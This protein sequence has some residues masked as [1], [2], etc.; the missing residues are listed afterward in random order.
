MFGRFCLHIFLCMFG[1][2]LTILLSSTPARAEI[3]IRESSL[4]AC[5]FTYS[6]SPP[7]SQ[8]ADSVNPNGVRLNWTDATV[9][10]CEDVL[11]PVRVFYIALPPGATARLTVGSVNTEPLEKGLA[12]RPPG[13]TPERKLPRSAWA[14]LTGIESWRGFRLARIEV[15]LQV[16]DRNHS[17]V[18]RRIELTV[19]FTGG[20][21]TAVH[22]RD[23]RILSRMAVNG[24]AAA[25]WWEAPQRRSTLDEEGSWPAY[26]LVRLGVTEAG[27]YEISGSSVAASALVGQPSAKIK[28]FGNG[29]RLLPKDPTA[30][31]DSALIEN[32]IWVLDGGDGRFDHQDTILFYGRGLKGADYCDGTYLQG[33][34]HYSPFSTEN[35]YFLGIDPAG[36]DG[37]RMAP[38]A[39]TG[40]AT[41]ISTSV[42]RTYLEQDVYVYGGPSQPE[43]G[44]MWYMSTLN[45]GQE[46]TFVMNLEGA[47]GRRVRLTFHGLYEGS[48]SNRFTIYLNGVR[49]PVMSEERPI[50]FSVPG[51]TVAIPG[52]NAIRLV[53][54]SSAA[55]HVNY[56]EL[57]Y[58]RTIS[59][60]LGSVEFFAP[61]SVDG[62]FRYSIPEL[63]TSAYVLNITN[64][65]APRLAASSSIV[66]STRASRRSR[67]F[68]TRASSMRT[69]AYRGSTARHNLDYVR[70]R[71]PSNSADMVILTFDE[72][73][74]LLDSLRAFH[75]TYR[76]QPLRTMRVRLTDV[77]DEFGWGV[78]DVVAIRNFLKYAFENWQPTASGEPLRYVLLVGDGDYDY[79]NIISNADANWMPPWEF[80]EDCCDDFF[81]VFRNNNDLPQCMTGRWPVQG[82]AELQAVMSKTIAYA[83]HPLYG[84]WKNTATFAADDEWKGPS[85]GET[86]HTTQ[87]ESLINTILPDYFTFKKIY[88]ILY[89]FRSTATGAT[90]PDATRDLIEAINRG[91][92][93]VNYTGHG[94]ERVWT[95]EQLF[96]M[97]RDRN[98]LDNPRTWPLFLA[99]TCTWGGFD[100]P[101]GRCFP[102][103]L[104]ADRSDGAIAC[105]AATRFTYVGPN[106]AFTNAYYSEL[107]RPG[108]AE[109]SSFGEALMVAKTAFN[110]NAAQYLTF[111]DPVLRLAT[112]EYFARVTQ[113]GD[114]LRAL[115][116]FHLSGEVS[117]TDT[118]ALW[119]DFQ[120]VVEA[121]VYDTEDSA[122]YYWCN[123]TSS[124]PFYY[125]LPGNAIFRGRA[126]VRN[127]R[128]DIAFLVPR[129]V[130]FG[131]TNAKISLYFFGRSD[132]DADSADGIGIQE[133]LAIASVASSEQDT[134]PPT[135][136]LWL[137]TASFRSGDVVSP[138]PRLHVDLVDS[139]GINLSGEVGHKITV[140]I[141]DAQAQDLT[142][143]FDYHLDSYTRGSLE[144]II[145]PLAEGEHQLVLEAWDSFNNLSRMSLAFAVG[146]SSEAGYALRDV[147]AWPN[148]MKDLTHFTYYLTQSGT[149]RVSVRV[150]TLTGKLVY[151]LDGLGTRGPAF[152]SNNE[153]PWDGRDREGHLLANGVYFY[154]IKAEHSDGHSAESTGKLVILR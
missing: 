79:R 123:N 3:K 17:S 107:F 134:V 25:L 98:L 33:L 95:D 113:R 49:F 153:Q 50:T 66:D 53:N 27:L 7:V 93:I 108:L 20:G 136:S 1:V 139:S 124:P 130:R 126:S 102:E 9:R 58:E 29:G 109:R 30:P 140:R 147:Y 115:S 149:R 74:D 59:A 97:D 64:P 135:I 68:A 11:Q 133:G 57:Q 40:E 72:G 129:D 70:L 4:S 116:I 67:Y 24:S 41:M 121:R 62:F 132:A 15:P 42:V 19:T 12:G 119:S 63:G 73:Y 145:G 151:E 148:P 56:I 84:P 144:K 78:H 10:I 118:G 26:D 88:E 61:D 141:D 110:T 46:R 37:L 52:N 154:R 104:L 86:S 16:G 82:V 14:E 36:A 80:N 152:N 55:I 112:P 96:V 5:A 101:I 127:G 60:P 34:T 105:V 87:A 150:F 111:G 22:P 35:I 51:D 99:A 85:C 69:P 44:L 6:P 21:R 65:L 91:T 143:Y 138:T 83:Q 106:N 75:E 23:V 128:F 89:P 2:A 43:S 47:T 137:E 77:Y 31:T 13:V 92:L 45:T 125:K 38:L 90:K 122:A 100:R 142:P 94:N 71:D 28:L 8:E 18:L 48:V 103:V 131:G 76:E 39:T 146:K 114:S 81:V 120:G 117:R 54:D 32:A